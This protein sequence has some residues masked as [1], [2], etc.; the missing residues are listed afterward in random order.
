MTRELYYITWLNYLGGFEYFPFTGRKQHDVDV[1]ETGVTRN[2][3][4]PNWDSSY[5]LNADTIDRQTFR[6]TKQGI[7]LR[8]QY[9]SVGQ[10]EAL[11][12]IRTS[13][14]VQQVNSRFDRRTLIVDADS[15]TVYD[16][17]DKT[18]QVSFRVTHTD[19]IPSQ[20]I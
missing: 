10:V 8:S 3:L 1:L 4:L 14:L 15:F 12:Y 5:G 18:F 19:E 16:E 2:N 20:P 13:P 7:I 6:R 9:V 17:K 11:K